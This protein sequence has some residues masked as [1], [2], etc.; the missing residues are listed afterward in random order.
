MVLPQAALAGITCW[1]NNEGVRECGNAV[2]PEY[3]QKRTRTLSEGGLTIDVQERAKT[4]DELAAQRR[5]QQQAEEQRK[6]Q[7]AQRKERERLQQKQAEYD[8]VLLSVFNTEADLIGSRDR[9]LS[10][11]DAQVEV[12]RNSQ[13]KLEEKLDEYRKRAAGLE[14]SGRPVPDTLVEDMAAIKRQISDKQGLITQKLEEKQRLQQ[15]YDGDL[16]RYRELT[17]QRGH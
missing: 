16:K 4:P 13:E 2:P 3:A 15:K 6:Q 17:R 12:A 10:A 9:K 14:R 11:I 5:E 8:R 7:E 1:T